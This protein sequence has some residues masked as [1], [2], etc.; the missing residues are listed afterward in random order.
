MQ[1]R[2]NFFVIPD[3]NFICADLFELC[4]TRECGWI[5]IFDGA[6]PPKV[7]LYVHAA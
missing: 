4:L 3:P 6:L 2:L 7:N 5:P 1:S